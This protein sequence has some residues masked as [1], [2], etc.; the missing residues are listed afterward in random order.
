MPQAPMGDDLLQLSEAAVK[1]V[2]TAGNDDDRQA[3][4]SCPIQHGSQRHHVVLIAVN[5]ERVFGHR[6]RIE[7]IDCRSDQGQA[8]RVQ[9]A[10]DQRL[11]VGAERKSSE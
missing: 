2:F 5:D 9:P 3:L 4:R 7:A 11:H 10:H 8:L 1:E 6:I